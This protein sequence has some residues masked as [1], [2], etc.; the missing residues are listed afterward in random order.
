MK[1]LGSEILGKGALGQLG[2]KYQDGGAY[3]ISWTGVAAAAVTHHRTPPSYEI[4]SATAGRDLHVSPKLRV[5]KW[6]TLVFVPTVSRVQ[7][8]KALPRETVGT[9]AKRPRYIAKTTTSKP[10]EPSVIVIPHVFG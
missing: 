3:A 2:K 7:S 5:T 9:I 6:S 1:S 10:G 8:M 4:L